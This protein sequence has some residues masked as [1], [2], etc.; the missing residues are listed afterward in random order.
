[1]DPVTLRTDRLLLRT[2]GPHDTDAVYRAV[3]DPDILRWT[4]MPSP[5]L[6][7]HAGS[8]TEQLV[9]DGWADGTMF[10]FGVFLPEGEDLI[11]MLGLTMRAPGVAEIGFW[12]AKEHRGKGYTSEAVLT[13]VRWSFT[14]AC[15]DRVEWRAEVGNTAS[16]AV[17]ERTGFTIEGTMRSAINNKGVRRD[18][19]VGSLLPSDLGLPSTA[20]YV[21]ARTQPA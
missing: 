21:P 7:E 17:A 11:G 4:T 15:I 16:R 3:Q 20:P 19:W 8:F 10:T 6:P 5:Y 1:M 18:C 9:P 2:V 14:A 12:T 13:A